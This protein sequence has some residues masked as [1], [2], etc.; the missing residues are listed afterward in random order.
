MG[1]LEPQFCIE[2]EAAVGVFQGDSLGPASLTSV[3]GNSSL[4]YCIL[5]LMYTFFVSWLCRVHRGIQA[6]QDQREKRYEPL[7]SS[8]HL[9]LV[10]P[11]CFLGMPLNIFWLRSQGMC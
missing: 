9:S 2:S 1:F 5:G 3:L 11:A 4:F 10:I 8:T 6:R 7:L